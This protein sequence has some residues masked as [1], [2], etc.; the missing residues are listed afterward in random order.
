[1][2]TET[3]NRVITEITNRLGVGY[4]VFSDAVSQ[5]AQARATESLI[6]SVAIFSVIILAVAIFFFAVVQNN[7]I[8]SDEKFII[9]L[10]VVA[11]LGFIIFYGICNLTDFINWSNAPQGMFLREIMAAVK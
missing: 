3:V 2:D 4:S 9:G 7:S 11:A 8:D 6:Y 5:Y 10:F 1:M